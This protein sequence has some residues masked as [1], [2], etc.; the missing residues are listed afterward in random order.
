MKTAILFGFILGLAGAILFL[1][2]KEVQ[3]TNGVTYTDYVYP[4]DYV[5]RSLRIGVGGG[6]AGALY[7]WIKNWKK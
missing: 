6:V 5:I 2:Y 3:H 7:S 1:P 4:M